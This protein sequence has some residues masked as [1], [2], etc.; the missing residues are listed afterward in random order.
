VIDRSFGPA[1]PALDHGPN[2]RNPFSTGATNR[3]G[4]AIAGD[5]A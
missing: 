5:H 2:W 3:T 1:E 4:R